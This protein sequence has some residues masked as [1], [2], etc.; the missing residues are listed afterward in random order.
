MEVKIRVRMTLFFTIIRIRRTMMGFFL[1]MLF[2]AILNFQ[3]ELFPV[4]AAV[5]E[6]Q[7]HERRQSWRKS[8]LKAKLG[9]S[10]ASRNP[11]PS[12]EANE[13]CTQAA[14]W[15]WSVGSNLTA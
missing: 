10:R 12:R 8:I 15:P 11:G 3:I 1:F 7:S 2:L 6:V 4:H 13:I 5:I 14:A 9:R